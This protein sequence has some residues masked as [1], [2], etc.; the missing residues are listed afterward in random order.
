MVPII[1]L[2][3]EREKE[4]L[5]QKEMGIPVNQDMGTAGPQKTR[6]SCRRQGSV[7]IIEEGIEKKEKKENK[8]DEEAK[9]EIR[10]D[11]AKGREIKTS[12][13]GN[14]LQ[15]KGAGGGGN[16]VVPDASDTHTQAGSVQRK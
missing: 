2:P 4:K 16:H 9:Q 10:F 8:G 11:E 12:D 1:D 15:H 13:I 7:G 6:S 3:G 14:I 5:A